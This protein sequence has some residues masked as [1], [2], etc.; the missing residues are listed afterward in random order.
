[1]CGRVSRPVRIS[2]PSIA[3]AERLWRAVPTCSIEVLRFRLG[4]ARPRWGI[5]GVFCF[6]I[7][8]F[9]VGVAVQRRLKGFAESF[10]VFRADF[11]VGFC[12]LPYPLKAFDQVLWSISGTGENLA[13]RFPSYRL[14][15]LA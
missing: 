4:A 6:G 3:R 8:V 15:Q 2:G 5:R 13:Q 11:R 10:S 14:C 9:E 1:M 12:V 7:L